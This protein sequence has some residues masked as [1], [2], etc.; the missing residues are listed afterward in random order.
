M[1]KKEYDH[2]NSQ[3]TGF[4]D[5][6]L[7]FLKEVDLAEADLDPDEIFKGVRDKSPGRDH[8][9]LFTELQIVDWRS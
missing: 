3:S 2:L 9:K 8:F 7:E 6:Y 1:D 4:W 5:G